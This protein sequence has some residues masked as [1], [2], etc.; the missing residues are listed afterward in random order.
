MDWVPQR[1]STSS[2]VSSFH[3]SK[4]C[5][6]RSVSVSSFNE[7][8]RASRGSISSSVEEDSCINDR[9]VHPQQLG[10]P[11]IRS[12]KCSQGVILLLFDAITS[13][14]CAYVHLQQAHIPYEPKMIK[15]ANELMVSELKNL[16]SLEEAYRSQSNLLSEIREYQKLLAKLHSKMNSKDSEICRLK[17]E[18]E[19]LDKQQNATLEKAKQ[20]VS[21]EDDLFP[22][23]WELTPTLFSLVIKFTAR[24]LHDF[25]KPLISLMKASFW[26]LDQAVNSLDNSIVYSERSHKKY[27]FEAYL[28]RS[29][30]SAAPRDESFTLDQFDRILNSQ[31]PFDAL[32]EDPN[33]CFGRFCRSKYLLVVSSKMECSFFGNLDQR[34]FVLN[35]CH[36]R[37]PFYQAFVKM[38]RWA[39]ALQVMANSFI[40][41]AEIF[42]A[43]KGCEFSKDFMKSVVDGVIP[44]EGKNLKVG[45]TVT[46]GYKI[47]SNIISCRVYLC[48]IA[49]PVNN[50]DFGACS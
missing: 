13:L 36:P 49:S 40:P 25:A 34:S 5:K 7:K 15:I 48:K 39:W 30:L 42:Y 17:L 11:W 33:S 6:R 21:A 18:I 24:S 19:E 44:K 9:K 31:D 3:F 2:S 4:L 45:F 14:K 41:Q 46:P 22:L 32:M 8:P 38:A 29:M 1:T 47:G 20:K 35:G 10:K 37:T 16:S 28:S 26:D 23:N 50:S 43:K 27:A 12:C